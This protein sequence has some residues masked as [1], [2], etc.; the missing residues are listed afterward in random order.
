[1]AT[2]SYPKAL[3][4]DDLTKRIQGWFDLRNFETKVV[5]EGNHWAVKARKTSWWRTAIAADRAINVNVR[6][7][8]DKTEVVV[9][10][11]DWTTNIVSNAVWFA[12]TGGMNL[13]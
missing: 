12:V 1:M 7:D 9:G 6:T 11:G 4:L 2:I 8:G 13:A 10:Q 5:G 3:D